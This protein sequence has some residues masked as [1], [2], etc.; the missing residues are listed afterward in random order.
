MKFNFKTYLKHTYKGELLYLAVIAALYFYDHNNIIFLIFFPFSF[1]QGYYRY[2]Y[3]LAQAEKLKA[4]GLTEED[5][6]N[7]SFVKKW[8]HARKRG[9]W[10]YCI[11]DGGV[12]F[13]AGYIT[14]YKCC[15]VNF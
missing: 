12:Y 11:I 2:Q 7:I 8:E 3:K 6:D 13:R 15:L 14:Y 9:K 4:K 1:I 10:N 5:I